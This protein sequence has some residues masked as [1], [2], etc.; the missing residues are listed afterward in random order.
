MDF[1]ILDE[2]EVEEANVGFV[3]IDREVLGVGY[4]NVFDPFLYV[5][6]EHQRR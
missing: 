3:E 5:G 6:G 4:L 2:I 1:G